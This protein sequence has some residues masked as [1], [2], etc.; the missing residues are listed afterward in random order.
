MVRH[1]LPARERPDVGVGAAAGRVSLILASPRSVRR[2]GARAGRRKPGRRESPVNGGPPCGAAYRAARVQ[3]GAVPIWPIFEPVA[4]LRV[5]LAG[6]GGSA[7]PATRPARACAYLCRNSRPAQA[8]R[9][10]IHP[11]LLQTRAR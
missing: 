4:V 8:P 6:R 1:V 7:P 3:L 5:I 2:R 10:P 11:A 9:Q